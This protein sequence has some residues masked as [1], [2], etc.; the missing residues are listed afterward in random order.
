MK[1][2]ISE[3][4]HSKMD[5]ILAGNT[6]N[7][8]D[9][10]PGN[11]DKHQ[12]QQQQKKPQHSGKI[13]NANSCSPKETEGNLVPSTSMEYIKNKKDNLK[14]EFLEQEEMDTAVENDYSLRLKKSWSPCS[15]LVPSTTASP[16]EEGEKSEAESQNPKLGYLY[17]SI[18][19]HQF[20][21]MLQV[22]INRAEGLPPCD[23]VPNRWDDEERPKTG[24]RTEA[25][26]FI[27][28]QILPEK[29]LKVKTRVLKRTRDPVYDETFSFYGISPEKIRRLSLHFAILS[30]DRF[31][32]DNVIGEVFHSLAEVDLSGK[33]PAAIVQEISPRSLKTINKN[34]G[35]ILIS[36]C[37][38]PTANKFI[39]GVLKAKDLPT[40]D[41]SKSA[42]PYVKVQ[43][44]H[45]GQKTKKKTEVKKQT[46]NPVFNESL[47]F[48]VPSEGLMDVQLEVIICNWDRVTKHAPLGTLCFSL[49]NEMKGNKGSNEESK[50]ALPYS[51]FWEA[52]QNPRK[53]V[54]KWHAL[55]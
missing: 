32:H 7:D 40:V 28:L 47:S 43:V 31:S 21:Q 10:N 39:V 23:R 26:P 24:I 29:R 54:A 41:F 16:V 11:G 36:L 12:Q 27:K 15:E 2:E 22:H 50:E 45:S 25:D 55:S 51:H 14:I 48:D 1:K 46:T 52:N 8:H 42:D 34:K 18:K 19:Y 38:E 13:N 9:P 35:E 4:I 6:F 37:H 44:T 20:K 33:D 3:F 53:A 30:F 49:Q 5:Q 17:Y